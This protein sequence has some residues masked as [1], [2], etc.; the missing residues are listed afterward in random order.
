M[1]QEDHTQALLDSAQE[2]FADFTRRE[3]L[4]P[5]PFLPFPKNELGTALRQVALAELPAWQRTPAAGRLASQYAKELLEVLPLETQSS[6]QWWIDEHPGANL[7][8][9]T[10]WL[11][12]QGWTVYQDD[13]PAVYALCDSIGDAAIEDQI[14]EQLPARNEAWLRLES[15]AFELG[16][17]SRYQWVYQARTQPAVVGQTRVEQQTTRGQ[18]DSTEACVTARAQDD[19]PPPLHLETTTH[20]AHGPPSHWLAQANTGYELGRTTHTVAA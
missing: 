19:L 13:Y 16:V 5:E 1:Q 8:D 18:A 7:S 14:Y 9:L 15:A 2:H 12:R 17:T 10:T 20:A 3:A 4:N 11:Y 6:L